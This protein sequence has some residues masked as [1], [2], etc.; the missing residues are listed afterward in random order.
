[1]TDGST[2]GRHGR[3]VVGLG[4]V[5]DL[6]DS[7]DD[8]LLKHF[9][10]GEFMDLDDGTRVTLHTERGFTVGWRGVVPEA[11]GSGDGVPESAE[12]L[13]D[14]V[15]NVVLPDGDDGEDHPWEWLAQLA[16]TRG[17]QVT[18]DDLR[19]LPYVVVLT[20]AVLS[21]TR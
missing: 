7:L 13:R 20:P 6:I 18:A 21:L 10:V 19:Q 9:S 4:A 14:T 12:M 8:G 2:A 1:M 5:C 11:D 17:V 3:K 16:R 15:L